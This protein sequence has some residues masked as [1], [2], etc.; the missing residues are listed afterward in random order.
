MHK[1]CIFPEIQLRG[2]HP[3]SCPPPPTNSWL[4]PWNPPL[5]SGPGFQRCELFRCCGPRSGGSSLEN[6]LHYQPTS[7]LVLLDFTASHRVHEATAKTC[8]LR[9]INATKSKK[10]NLNIFKMNRGRSFRKKF[11]LKF[12][13]E[14]EFR[15]LLSENFSQKFYV[16]FHLK[17]SI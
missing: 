9:G 12:E 3:P 14:N 4:H 6:S 8:A 16:R 13:N 7:A 1:V 17:T 5:E 15:E 2:H 11:G 10:F